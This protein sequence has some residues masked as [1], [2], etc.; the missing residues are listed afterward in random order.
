MVK[1]LHI[2]Q[3]VLL[4]YLSFSVLT[5]VFFTFKSKELV[6]E[7]LE[8]GGM[9]PQAYNLSNWAVEERIYLGACLQFQCIFST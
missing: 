6:A 3:C 4:S 5:H 7:S 1:L 9:V 2:K 8:S